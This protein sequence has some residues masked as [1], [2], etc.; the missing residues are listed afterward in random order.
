MTTA[1]PNLSTLSAEDEPTW[2]KESKQAKLLRQQL[3]RRK[4]HR[5]ARG[6]ASTSGLDVFLQVQSMLP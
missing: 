4:Q 1:V 5:L 2:Q 3:K 6:E